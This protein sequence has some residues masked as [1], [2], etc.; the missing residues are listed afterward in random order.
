MGHTPVTLALTRL[1]QEECWFQ[2]SLGPGVRTQEKNSVTPKELCLDLK[3]ICPQL[4]KMLVRRQEKVHVCVWGG[5][6]F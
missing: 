1:R 6:V 5:A 2:A 4:H 3:T